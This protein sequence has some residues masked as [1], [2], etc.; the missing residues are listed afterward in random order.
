[1]IKK[2]ALLYVL[3]S[4]VI[5]A[6]FFGLGLLVQPL[7]LPPTYYVPVWPSAGFSVFVVLFWGYKYLPAVALGE[8]LLILREL[9][10][11][12]ISI[13]N[14]QI[15]GYSISIMAVMLRASLGAYLIK[16]FLGKSNY[17]LTYKSTLNLF[18]LGGIVPTF[19]SSLITVFFLHES[20]ILNQNLLLY[21]FL[22]WWVGDSIGVFIM[23][24][25][26]LTLFAKPKEI[27]GPRRKR[28]IIPVA[29][30]L[31]LMLFISVS[32]KKNQKVRLNTNLTNKIDTVFNESLIRF[33]NNHVLDNWVPKQQIASEFN[34]LL[35]NYIEV[36]VLSNQFQDIHFK[37]KHIKK[38]DEAIV[39]ESSNLPELD[40]AWNAEKNFEYADNTWQIQASATSKYL[41]DN[42]SLEIWWLLST[43]F[44]FISLLGASLL[45]ITGHEVRSNN[46]VERRT[47]EIKTLNEILQ[48]SE[49]RYKQLVEIQPVIFWKH[50]RGEPKV[51]FV[52]SEGMS[53]LG[54]TNEELKDLDV[55]W[56]KIIHPDDKE[57]VLADYHQMVPTGKRFTI[58][59]RALNKNG[60]VLWFRDYISTREVNGRIE[61]IGMKVD[62]TTEQANKQEI[63]TLAYYDILTHLP[64]R[65]KFEQYLVMAI[66]QAKKQNSYGAVI[67]FDIDRFK[68]LNDSMG[69]YFGD[70]LL[71]KIANRVNDEILDTGILARISGDEFALLIDDNDTSI[72]D[73]R[74]KADTV[75]FRIQQA[76]NKPFVLEGHSFYISMSIGISVFPYHADT[77]NKII[78]YAGIAMYSAKSEAKSSVRFFTNDMLEEVSE[79]LEI[80]KSLKTALLQNQYQIYYQPIF[81]RNKK[82]VKME[83]LIR[84]NHPEKGLLMPS[85]FIETA[86]ETGFIVELTEWIIDRVFRQLIEWQNSGKKVLPVSINISLFQFRHSGL[87]EML[88]RKLNKYK[89]NPSLITIEITESVGIDDIELTMTKLKAIKK[90]GFILA[91]DDFGTGYSSLNYLTRMPIDIIKL[92]MSFVE[93]IGQEDSVDTLIETIILMANMLNFEVIVE[94]V[95]TD[96]Q[97]EFLKNLG[98]SSFQGYLVS[99]AVS[100]SKVEKLYL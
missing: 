62:I 1:M 33:S 73:I 28:I 39:Y 76:L 58:K 88:S 31:L 11:T 53:L 40:R 12:D 44:F 59:Y 51:E 27:W 82:I 35:K 90:L 99:E 26:L 42:A 79:K 84:W 21:D 3:N 54:Y 57:R 7:I 52:S 37:I 77:V 4:I 96:H 50:I 74:E 95:E 64:N 38:G 24:P 85:A 22:G 47:R 66:N 20:G 70:R 89:I 91:I 69:N 36:L 71:I 5:A 48:D 41:S 46:L 17:Y 78:Q 60:G 9:G 16:R 10:Y 100:V 87:V 29:L 94:G 6:V 81:D 67:Y 97:F 8:M 72:E 63:E 30:S 14:I 43:G 32:L 56:N 92:D 86:E 18:Y 93:K 2:N 61:V 65:I 68:V 23:L 55:L 75:V 83:A 34:K 45:T 98:C 19:I 49:N 25:L 15:L 80:E 13:S